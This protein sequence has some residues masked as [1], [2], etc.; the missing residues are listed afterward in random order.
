MTNYN[1]KIIDAH[2][3]TLTELNPQ[4][5]TRSSLVDCALHFNLRKQA[6]YERFLLVTDLWVDSARHD[7]TPRVEEFIT[8]F[9]TQIAAAQKQL[10]VRQI[11]DATDLEAYFNG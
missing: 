4:E 10:T 9:N 7:V 1:Y 8:L 5:P 6:L 11:L 3:D 2:C